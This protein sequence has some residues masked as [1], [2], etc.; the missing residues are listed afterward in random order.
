MIYVIGDSHSQIFD[1]KPIEPYYEVFKKS[2]KTKWLTA[3][4]A[5]NVSKHIP[6]VMN[7][8]SDNQV[9]KENDMLLFILGEIDARVHL[10]PQSYKQGITYEESCKLCTTKYHSFLNH[11]KNE[12]YQIIVMGA[13]PSGPHNDRNGDGSL[14][15]KTPIERNQITEIFNKQVK[16]ICADEGFIYRDINDKITKGKHSYRSY[17]GTVSVHLNTGMFLIPSDGES[18]NDILYETFKDL[19]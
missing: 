3:A 8:L 9:D 7:W 19:L 13:T 6:D 2:F 1:T 4:T 12:G 17:F 16:E 10:G 18:C 5:F 15:Y 14:S 11:F